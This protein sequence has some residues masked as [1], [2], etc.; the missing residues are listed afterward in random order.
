MKKLINLLMCG[1]V[2][3]AQAFVTVGTDGECDLGVSSFQSA[4]QTNDEVRITNQAEFPAVEI[5]NRSVIIRGGYDNCT[6]AENN[7]GNDFPRS[8][9][10]GQDANTVMV[11]K[12]TAAG[13]HIHR[14]I[15]LDNVDLTDGVTSGNNLTGG[16]FI[17]GNVE[18]TT[19]G[20]RIQ[21]NEATTHGGGVYIYGGDG[22]TLV[23]N[24]TQVTSND[25][26]LGGGMVISSGAEVTINAGFIN[27]NTASNNGGGILVTS[28]SKLNSLIQPL[29]TTLPQL[30][31]VGCIVHQVN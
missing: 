23:M 2:I 15:T 8:I 1:M 19:N 11:L 7:S 27:N 25:A 13:G 30:V 14:I 10:S 22:A 21:N 28:G 26:P 31:V 5:I 4:L 17:T 6:E 24:N 16:L 29:P 3:N 9:I 12:T 18:V 20:V